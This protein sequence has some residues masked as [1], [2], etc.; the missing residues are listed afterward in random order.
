VL[1]PDSIPTPTPEPHQ[2][3]EEWFERWF[4][5]PLY[6]KLY[7]HRDRTEAEHCVE[8][9]LRAVAS[10]PRPAPRHA[11]DLA[12]GPGRHSITLSRHG[13]RVTAVDLSPT[14]LGHALAAAANE[15]V[16]DHIRFLRS[17][18]RH[19][20]FHQEFDL[21]VQ[22][23]TSFGYFDSP[24]DD[25]LVLERVRAA[26]RPGG[27]YA[28]DLL[29]EQHLRASLMNTSTKWV[30]D[31]EVVERRQIV[32]DRVEKTII[33]HTGAE[34]MEF[35][36]SVRLYSPEAI[37]LMLADAGL[38]PVQWFGDYHGSAFHPQHSARMLVIARAE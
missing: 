28:L 13:L 35:H 25:F 36:E 20:S 32:D 22:L 26:L 23:F 37:A 9:I 33:I 2:Q 8:L 4:R 31:L 17:D 27:H 10:G 19:I 14:L 1:K 38:V 16:E 12:C 30:D 3:T 7:A 21:A 18:M 29:N 15:G 11:L 34:Q 6:L 5:N 24:A